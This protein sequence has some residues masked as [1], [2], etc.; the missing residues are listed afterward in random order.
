M[1]RQQSSV[2]RLPEDIREQLQAL[3]R[4]PRCT[5]IDATHR[6]NAIL[7]AEGHPDRI[8]KSAVNRYVGRMEEVGAKLRE[9]REIAQ[10]WI[11][12]LGAEPQGEVG[13]LLNEMVRTLA[14]KMA[15]RAHEGEDDEP[16]DPKLLKSLAIS[17]YRLER[18]ASENVKLEAEIRKRTLAEAAKTAG[19]TAKRAGLSDEAAEQIRRKILGI[20]E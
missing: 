7:E 19:A 14:F 15:M 6:I 11:G 18:A 10:M 1:G 2:D 3:L 4:D 16:I 20:A 8:S 5:Q 17:V 13:K 9:T 12:K